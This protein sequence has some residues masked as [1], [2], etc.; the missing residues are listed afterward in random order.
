MK[1]AARGNKVMFFFMLYYLAIISGGVPIVAQVVGT[2]LLLMSIAIYLIGMLVPFI[3]YMIIT[4]Q[5]P[6]DVLLWAPFGLRSAVLVSVISLC[7]L[8][9]MYLI[10][11]ISSY[12]LVPSSLYL[13]HEPLWA[14]LIVGSVL[15]S[16]FGGIWYIGVIY[17]EYEKVSI[18]RTAVIIGL[19]F[20]SAQFSFHQAVYATLLG[21]LMAYLV[22]YTRT[23]LAPVL[24]YFIINSTS[25]IVIYFD[26]LTEE[27]IGS[28]AVSPLMYCVVLGGVSLVFTPVAVMC[29]KKLIAH[30]ES[31]VP[32]MPTDD[33]TA[34]KPR[35]L[36]WAFWAVMT[37]SI[38]LMW[39]VEMRMRA[40]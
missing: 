20:G 1:S 37:V 4:R 22:Y 17:S 21:I 2:S 9:V 14:M 38:Y 40:M 24:M 26:F 12:I 34:P 10:A 18:K 31:I 19:F 39:S 8:P 25:V 27:Y 11:F 7:V 15:P 33:A 23:I 28:L 3:I 13:S 35:V 29:F 36:T 32:D 16:I 6:K 5:K 30:R